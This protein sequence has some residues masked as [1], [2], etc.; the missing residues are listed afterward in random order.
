MKHYVD[1]IIPVYNAIEELKQCLMSIYANTD[2][3][4]NRIILINDNSSDLKIRPYLDEQVAQGENILVIHNEKNKGFSA[5]I[6]IGLEQSVIN[7]VIL[8]NSDTVVTKGWIDKMSSCAYSDSAIATVTPLSNNATLCSVPN[9]C[10]ENILP[11]ELSIEE[12]AKIVERCSFKEFPEITVAHGF[13]MFIKREVI[14]VIGNFDEE[15]FG[16]GY[17]EENDFC[18][19]AEQVGYKHVMCDNTY[20]YH[21]GTKSFATKEKEEYI[22]RHEKILHQRYPK[23]MYNNAIHCRDNPNKKIGENINIYFNLYNDKKNLLF[24]VQSDFR[25]GANDNIGG[26]QL[27]VHDL[28]FSLKEQYNVFVVARDGLNITV[29]AYVNENVLTFEFRIPYDREYPIRRDKKLCEFWENILNAFRIDLIHVHHI[30]RISFDV[31]EVAN[32][33]KIPVILTLHD[34]YFVCPT[35]KLLDESGEICIGHESAEKCKKCL[36]KQLGYAP[37]VNYMWIWRKKCEEY[38]NMVNAIIVPSSSAKNILFHYY[39]NIKDKTLV[40]EHGYNEIS[41]GINFENCIESNKVVSY[42]EQCERRGGG[43][44]IIGWAYEQGGDCR[45]NEVWLQITNEQNEISIIPTTVQC[46]SDVSSENT[47]MQC[48]FLGYLPAKMCTGTKIKVEI[49]IKTPTSI[50]KECNKEKRIIKIKAIRKESKLNVAFIGGLNAAKGGVKV[51]QI[52]KDGPK[53]VAWFVFGGIGI[54]DLEHLDRNSLVKTGYYKP[55]QLP[56][57]LQEHSIDVICILSLWPETY[58]Y[59]LTE[60]IL[61]KIP[62]IVTNVGALGERVGKN[63]YGWTVELDDVKNGVIEHVKKILEDNRILLEKKKNP[64]KINIRDGEDMSKDYF[65]LYEKNIIKKINYLP[66]NSDYIYHGYLRANYPKSNEFGENISFEEKRK[67]EAALVNL[68]N[69]QNSLTYK[70][71]RKLLEIKFPLKK[72]IKK[73]LVRNRSKD[74]KR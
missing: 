2:L 47:K 63:N 3:K 34:F 54:E 53:D 36:N 70:I 40:I 74:L 35:I 46:R 12:A 45:E 42:Y 28:V 39:P 41:N 37:T 7:D 27:H 25:A 72:Q 30:Y 1:I 31:F 51:A 9:F 49:I 68:N 17:G 4:T 26:T 60:A 8:L 24:L 48:G 52:I 18:N 32:E 15:T 11:A 20:I 66:F 57:L 21:S 14:E 5:N 29:T 6:N 73:L 58:S 19:R 33:M 23:Q 22:K 67:L 59:T 43:Y 62:T 44:C 16:R 71:T 56:V 61:N 13:C 64:E 65:A 55:N 38:L 10:E 50:L 69:I